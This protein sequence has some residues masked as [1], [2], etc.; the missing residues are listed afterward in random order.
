M[1][2][3]KEEALKTLQSKE[4]EAALLHPASYSSIQP[5]VIVASMALP[6]THPL[7]Q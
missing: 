4:R 6:F 1:D 5:R 2:N 7:L 3:N